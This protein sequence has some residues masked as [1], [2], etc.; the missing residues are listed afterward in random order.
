MPLPNLSSLCLKISSTD[1]LCITFPGGAEVCV[2]Y[3]D[4][5]IPDPS[6]LINQLFAMLN[7]ALA[8]LAPIFTILEVLIAIIDCIK[9]IQK[10]LAHFPPRPDALAKCFPRLAKALR[11]LLRLIPFLSIPVLIG[12][13]LDAIIIFLTG[14]RNQLLAMIRKTLRLIA[15]QLK[16]HRL[17][18]V[19]LQ[20]VL[21]CASGDVDAAMENMSANAK[22]L[23]RMIELVNGFM[24]LA[25]L[26]PI[27]PDPSTLPS[28]A[29]AAIA[30]IDISIK[31]L[32]IVRLGFP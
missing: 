19:A 23:G 7:A 1:R 31:A 15:A 9:A 24:E 26:D 13:I 17:P 29:G 27:I 21:D 2:I 30:P 18:S 3:P 4:F 6:E 20:T 22:P 14:L 12:G 5:K 28:N 8:P 32:K 11:K 10:C 25:G 16:A